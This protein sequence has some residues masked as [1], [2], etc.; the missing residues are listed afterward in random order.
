[1]FVNN[2]YKLIFL[3]VA[4][5]ALN[6]NA[7]ASSVDNCPYEGTK[8]AR[9]ELVDLTRPEGTLLIFAKLQLNLLK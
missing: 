6:S 3:L 9:G 4:I 8:I 5:N 7:Y 1:M 2:I